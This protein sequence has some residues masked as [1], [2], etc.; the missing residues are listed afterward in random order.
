MAPGI[1][2]PME[3]HIFR[4]DTLR[5]A[6]THAVPGEAPADVGDDA[7]WQALDR[8]WYES[9]KPY[10][11]LAVMAG[12][13]RSVFRDWLHHPSYDH[14][15][16]RTSPF[17]KQFARIDRSEEHTSELQSL[18]RISYAVFCLKKKKRKNKN[19]QERQKREST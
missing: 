11:D 8:Q 12:L 9:G 19:T 2:F 4:N 10:R 13:P 5:W 14:Y 16:E 6:S 1:S 7:H 3:G 15:W 17:G 18:M